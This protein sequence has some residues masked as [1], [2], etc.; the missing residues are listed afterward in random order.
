MIEFTDED[1]DSYVVGVFTSTKGKPCVKLEIGDLVVG[2]LAKDA[3]LICELIR[4]AAAR[5]RGKEETKS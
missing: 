3:N 1:G 4:L 2:F 5:A